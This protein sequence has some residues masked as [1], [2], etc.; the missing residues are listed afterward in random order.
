MVTILIYRLNWEVEYFGLDGEERKALGGLDK[1]C[2]VCVHVCVHTR[3]HVH[4]FEMQKEE[5]E[6]AKNGKI[7]Q[8]VRL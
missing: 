2:E 8:N 4:A 6:K 3:V 7:K 1:S 5:R